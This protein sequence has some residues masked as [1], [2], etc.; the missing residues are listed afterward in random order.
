M[1]NES[2][3]WLESKKDFKEVKRLVNDIRMDMNKAKVSKE[4]K[5]V[6]N[7]LNKLIT[8]ISNNKVKKRMLLKD[9]KKYVS[10]GSTKEKTKYFFSK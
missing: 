5:K 4:D 1:N 9:W 7:G 10:L 3:E 6:F 2:P 8:D